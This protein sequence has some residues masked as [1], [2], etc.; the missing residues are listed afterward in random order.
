MSDLKPCPFCGSTD[1][2]YF[3]NS[4]YTIGPSLSYGMFCTGCGAHTELHDTLDEA[5]KAWNRRVNDYGDPITEIV[6]CRD[7]KWYGIQ[8]GCFFSTAEIDSA[9]FCSFGERREQ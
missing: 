5:I 8:D 9:G 7:C 3:D 4:G 6:R 2:L 1:I